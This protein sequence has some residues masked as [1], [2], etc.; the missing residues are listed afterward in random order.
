MRNLPFRRLPHRPK[1]LAALN[2]DLIS[3]LR[4][5]DQRLLQLSA[6]ERAACAVD[7]PSRSATA[8]TGPPGCESLPLTAADA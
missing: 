1:F 3:A 8:V 2:Q 7:K 6:T 4:G 5:A